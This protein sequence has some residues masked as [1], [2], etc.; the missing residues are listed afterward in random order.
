MKVKTDRSDLPPARLRR[1]LIA[2]GLLALLAVPPWL[3]PAAMAQSPGIGALI[4]GHG[5]A[6]G[7]PYLQPRRER[8]RQSSAPEGRARQGRQRGERE[9]GERQG[10]NGAKLSPDER[11]SLRQSLYDLGREMYQGS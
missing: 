10:R 2:G 11:R 3:P 4:H 1:R 5:K 7:R 8:E 6:P 9:G